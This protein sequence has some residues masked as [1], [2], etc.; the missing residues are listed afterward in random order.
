MRRFYWSTDQVRMMTTSKIISTLRRFGVNF[1]EKQFLQDIQR[2]FSAEDIAKAWQKQYVITAYGLDEDFIWMACVVLWERLA[3]ADVLSTEQLDDMM[4]RGYDQL[5]AQD[6]AAACTQWLEVWER[7]KPRFS[8]DITAIEAAESVFSGSQFLSN[9]CQDIEVELWNTGRS[10]PIFYEHRL[11]YCR[12]FCA[13][14]PDSDPLIVLNMKRAEAET[15]VQL[16]HVAEGDACFQ[17][18]VNEFPD[19]IWGYIGWGDMYARDFPDVVEPDYA[20]AEQIY[21]MA[22]ARNLADHDVVE[23]RLE[24]LKKLRQSDVKKQGQNS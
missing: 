17:R 24:Y 3:P 7:L 2:A 20:K 6:P 15:L 21:R 18:L 1:T 12:E 5:A 14:F 9:W 13:L 22:L 10:D 11:R 23:Q 4:Q 8:E 16:G 19:S